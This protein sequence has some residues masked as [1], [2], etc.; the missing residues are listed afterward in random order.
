MEVPDVLDVAT[1]VDGHI[2]R[3]VLAARLTGT[4]ARLV[5]SAVR[6][7]LDRGVAAIEVDAV[8]VDAVDAAGVGALVAARE[9]AVDV[10]SVLWV[11]ARPEVGRDITRLAGLG[12]RLLV[13][14]DE[15]GGRW[16]A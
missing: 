14:T 10:G 3:V 8:R 1:E 4:S 9:A 13:M 11:L 2:G 6:S 12:S 16:P 7:L 15:P 5:P